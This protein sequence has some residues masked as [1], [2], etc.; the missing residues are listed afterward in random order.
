MRLYDNPISGNCYKV[1]LLL[2]LTGKAYECV[3]IDSLKGGTQ[4]PSFLAISPRGL[5]PVLEDEDEVIADSMAILIYLARRYAPEWLP[6]SPLEQARVMEWLA[7]A[8][9]EL[10]YGAAVSRRIK[11][12]GVAGDLQ[13]AQQ[14]ARKGLKLLEQRLEQCNW[15]VGA[16]PPS[17]ILPAT[18]MWPCSRKAGSNLSPTPRCNSG[19][20][21]S[22]GCLAMFPCPDSD[23]CFS[24]I[25]FKYRGL[26][27]SKKVSILPDKTMFPLPES[28]CLRTTNKKNR[29]SLSPMTPR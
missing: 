4:Q 25:L 20:S 7:I 23:P 3:T 28:I 5:I 18:P 8:A 15:L 26:P 9:D 24:N 10:Q 29:K 2:A 6:D 1:R 21:A 13:T 22:N 19:L 12:L 11:K 16:A 14:L 17:P 27:R